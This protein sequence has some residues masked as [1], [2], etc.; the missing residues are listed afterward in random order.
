MTGVVQRVGSQVGDTGTLTTTLTGREVATW[1]LLNLCRV[2]K[3]YEGDATPA[4]V[5]NDL[6]AEADVTLEGAVV[7]GASRPNFV[8]QESN[9][10]NAI[11]AVARWADTPVVIRDGVVVVGP[12]ARVSPGPDVDEDSNL[13][14]LDEQQVPQEDRWCAEGENTAVATE[15]VKTFDATTLGNPRLRPGQ[16]VTVKR[17]GETPL[18]LRV[19]KVIHRFSTGASGGYT[20]EMR[21]IDPAATSPPAHIGAAGVVRR[22]R[23]LTNLAQD[24]RPAVDVGEVKEYE[25]GKDGK[26]LASLHYGQSPGPDVVEPSVETPV[27]RTSQLNHKPVASPF[28]W[29]KCGLVVPVYP[30]QRALLAHNRSDPNDAVVA[31]FL[32][33]E[34]PLD[35]RPKSEPGDWWLCLPTELSGDRPSGK[36]ANDLTDAAGLRVIQAKGFH[37]MVGEDLL[38]DVGERPTPPNANELTIEHKSGTKV[39]I[40]DD[41]KVEVKGTADVSLTNGSVTLKLSGSA[42]D[43]S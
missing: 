25:P 16:T 6:V 32:W 22:M 15:A 12:P 9:A 31:G 42:V 20:C 7:G 3:T 4:Q 13:V 1:R 27:N 39:T 18:P 43:V 5:L 26:H 28:A 21:L 35:E 36:G 11:D 41:G 29:H 33:A 38:P 19:Q 24:N 8:L 17:S 14:K 37:L 34:D 23:D 30:K 40:A 10:L 2:R